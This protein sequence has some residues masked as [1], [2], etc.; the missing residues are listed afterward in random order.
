M[1]VRMNQIPYGR[2]TIEEEDVQNIIEVLRSPFIT[3]GPKVEEFEELVAKYHDAKYGIAFSSGTAAL[4]GAYNAMGVLE[5]DE[6]ITST[7]TFVATANAAV[8]C[9]GTPILVD[10]DS[11]TNCFDL[12]EVEKKVT[13]KTKVITAVSMAGYPVDLEKVR[14]IADTQ[15]A[16]VLHDAA[17]A[18]GSKRN[19]S[20]G[21]E[22]AHM[23]MISF[24][25]VKHV[26]TGEGGM[27]LTNDKGLYNKLQVFR[28]HGITK[29]PDL[30]SRN[31]GPWYYEMQSLGYNYRMTDIQA[32][33]GICQFR[34]LERNLKERNQIAEYYNEALSQLDFCILPPVFGFEL[35]QK[36]NI[37]E[38]DNIHAYHLYTLRLKKNID[39]YDFF[40][41]LKK[42]GINAQIHYIPVH[43]QPYYQKEYGYREGVFPK[44][45]IYYNSEVSIPLFHNITEEIR[46]YVVKVIS[47]Y[48][49]QLIK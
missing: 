21:L 38:V 3:Q 29:N 31:D 24:H 25:P 49:K 6:I 30:M 22:H 27:I 1:E 42:H 10:I 19:G 36:D 15:G 9:G 32:A 12:N 41:Y 39:R 48:K 23:A 16:Y 34:R 2:Q 46:K 11:D 47:D 40:M 18:I 44:S 7:L 14:Q 26:T 8:Y 33:L 37:A 20:F 5:G 35:L 43:M 17:H 13:N 45:E 4:H 28:S